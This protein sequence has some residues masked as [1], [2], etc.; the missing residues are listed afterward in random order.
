MT[1]RKRLLFLVAAAVAFSALLTACQSEDKQ[2]DMKK[3]TEFA[4]RYAAAW[5][6]QDPE[7][8]SLFYAEHGSLR[9]NGGEPSMGRDAIAETA[10]SFM[11][12]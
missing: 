10:R 12:A 11:A 8:F 2:N 9:V 3:L 4:V 1:I 5:S 6:N 7:A